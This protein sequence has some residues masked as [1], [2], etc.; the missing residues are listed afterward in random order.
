MSHRLP[1]WAWGPSLGIH[2]PRPLVGRGWG[3]GLAPAGAST[4]ALTHACKDTRLSGRARRANRKGRGMARSP[5]GMGSFAQ[6]GRDGTPDLRV[7]AVTLRAIPRW[8]WG[9]SL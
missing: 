4:P 2:I 1:R 6:V 3:R 7:S 9:P 8:A 5:L